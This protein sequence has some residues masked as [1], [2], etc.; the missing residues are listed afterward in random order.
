MFVF[1]RDSK[2]PILQPDRSHTWESRAAFNWCPIKITGETH[3]LYRAESER[4]L[5]HGGRTTS[6]IGH[7]I[8][9]DGGVHK[10][11]QLIAPE[12]DWDIYG[13]EDPRVTYFEGKYYIFYTALSEYP[14]NANGIKVA[15]AVSDDLSSVRERHLVTPFNAKAMTLFP[16]RIN[17][18]I[19]VLLTI[20]PDNP[21]AHTAFFTCKNIEDLW[22]ESLWNEWYTNFND[23][24]VDLRRYE[25][26]HIEIGAPPLKTKEGWLL[27][28]S[29]IQNYF[30]EE[31]GFGIEVLLLDSKDPRKVKSR[32]AGAFC[33]PSEIYERFGHVPNIVFPSGAL[34]DEDRLDIYY[35]ATDTT[36]CRGSIHLPHLI[37]HLQDNDK[38]LVSRPVPRPI[39]KPLKKNE[40]EAQ[41]VFNP[42]AID[43]DDEIHIIYRAL[44]PDNTSRLGYA[45]SKNGLAI[46]SRLSEPIYEPRTEFESKKRDLQGNSGCEDARITRIDDTLYLLYTAYDQELPRVAVSTL[47]VDDFRAQKWNW[48]E[49]IIVSPEGVDDKDACLFPAK[50]EDHY[51][52]I[53]RIDHHV[54]ADFLPSLDFKEYEATKCIQMLEPRKGMWDS[55]KIGI[56]STPH[57]TKKGWLWLYHGV[58]EDNIYRVGAFLTDLDDPTSVIGRTA[59][60]IF[61]PHYKWEKEGVIPNVVFPCGSVIRDNTMFIYYGG[62]D[63]VIGVVT[64]EVKEL[65]NILTA[66]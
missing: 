19:A 4:D 20:N 33:T 15:V 2:N 12:E 48:S 61:E 63:T 21:P 7:T 56:A 5:V 39:L 49:P 51:I 32:T 38:Q 24:I 58:S 29:H 44:S 40:W 18:N 28:Y 50:H 34:I 6:S 54:C 66:I 26:E 3:V 36:C 55:Q 30:S 31:K 8:L 17:G 23:H 14:Y 11:E 64:L 13:C 41:A 22:N 35:G 27:V 52:L 43:I 42:T 46:D 65:L 62:A 47:S 60:P 37:A 25:S 10:R 9:R 16:E 59:A 45:S 1:K 53:H 57:K